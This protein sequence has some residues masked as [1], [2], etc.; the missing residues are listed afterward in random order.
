MRT[1]ASAIQFPENV[2]AHPASLDHCVLRGVRRVSMASSADPIVGVRMVEAAIL[3]RVS[4]FV[5]PVIPDRYVLIVAR[6][7]DTV[8]GASKG[9]NASTVRIATT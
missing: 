5:R 8:C 2:I 7:K 4:V 9:V 1:G 6:A 3:R